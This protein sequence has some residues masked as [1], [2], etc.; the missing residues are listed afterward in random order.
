M[1]GKM[2]GKMPLATGPILMGMKAGGE[3]S[4]GETKNRKR[5]LCIRERH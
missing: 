1:I 4:L 5:P 3:N 2:I